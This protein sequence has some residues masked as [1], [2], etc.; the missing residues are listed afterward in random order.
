MRLL[1]PLLLLL[2]LVASPLRAAE[3]ADGIE[4]VI[5]DQIAAFQRNDVETAFSH[6]SPNIRSMFRTPENFGQMV[7]RGYPMIWRPSSYQWQRLAERGGR[8][9]QTVMFEDQSGQLFEAD[10]IMKQADGVWQIDGVTLRRLPG[11]SS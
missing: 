3:P 1:T 7:A 8:W 2:A 6:A 11:L 9:I 10:Y 4:A 5:A